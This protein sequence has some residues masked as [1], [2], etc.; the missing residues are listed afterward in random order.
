[1]LAG[2]CH[3]DGV[4]THTCASHVR[5]FAIPWTGICSPARLLHPW[6]SPGKNTG[7]GCHFLLQEIF[8]TQKLNL[9]LLALAG[10]FFT[11]LPGKPLDVAHT[12]WRGDM[13]TLMT[14]ILLWLSCGGRASAF[15]KSPPQFFLRT[16]RHICCSMRPFYGLPLQPSCWYPW[17]PC[18][19]P[20]PPF[21]W[22][23]LL[24]PSLWPPIKY[25]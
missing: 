22:W 11:E 17:V 19:S 12:C 4:C 25:F 15:P 16:C 7:V 1:M 5:L 18:P 8:L 3:P 20:M 2:M 6:D 24:V 23:K 10:G 21:L 14:R 9:C 13:W